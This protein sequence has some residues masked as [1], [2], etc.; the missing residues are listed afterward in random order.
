M[1][2]ER[3]WPLRRPLDL[4]RTVGAL[5]HGAGD[6]VARFAAGRFWW[7]TR[8]PDGPGTV[9][10][11]LADQLVHAQ[12]WGPGAGWMLAQV[13]DLIGESDDWSHLDTSAHARLHEVRRSLPGVRLARTGRVLD[14][15]V[16][17]VLE[18]RVTG[19]EAFRAWRLLTRHYGEPAP[20]PEQ[21]RLWLPAEPATLLQVPS[22]DWHR[23]GVDG[24]RH[25]TV[26]A[27]ATVAGRL[28]ECAAMS[29]DDA[30]RR[31]RSVPGVG[32]WTAA[33]TT[34]RAL[35]DADAVSV[36]DFHVA[37]RV[38]WFLAG[39]PRST[40]EQMLELLAPWQG[41]RARVVKLIELSG[42]S[43]PKY[44]PRFSPN[45]IRRI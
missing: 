45:D 2:L 4:R 31:L 21:F 24:Q 17:A 44:G 34:V 13:P 35:G 38:G 18:Q 32:Q 9:S 25:R 30:T 28:E 43:P 39:R 5:C 26:R 23:F 22:W 3:A 16:P 1:P 37:N 29:A 36:G 7:A 14:S 40:D 19:Q 11:W 33:E 12:A 20:G 41:Q 8:S 42:F 10:V 15:L 6:P 27:V